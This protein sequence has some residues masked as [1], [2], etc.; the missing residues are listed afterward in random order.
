MKDW[1]SGNDW[2]VSSEGDTDWKVTSYDNNLYLQ[3]SAN[4][5]KGECIAWLITPEITLKENDYL[6]FDLKVGYWNA[7]CL[8]VWIS[9]NFDGNDVDAATW[10][11]IT[12]NFTIPQVPTGG[13]GEFANAGKCELEA[14][15]GN[16]VR[17][18]FKY[19][20]DGTK[21]ETTTYQI[22]NIMI[23]TA[24]P[25]NGGF[26]AE[27]AYA[28]KVYKKGKWAEPDKNVYLLSYKD[29]KDMG[30]NSLN[31]TSDKPAVNYIPTY[32]SKTVAY[33]LDGDARVVIYRYDNGEKISIRSDEYIYSSETTRW[34]LNNNIVNKTEQYVLKDGKWNFDPSTVI[35]LK[36]DKSDT[37][38]TVFYTAIVDWVKANKSDYI[39]SYNNNEYYYGS[40]FYQNNFDFRLSKWKEYYP[41]KTDEEVKKLMWERLPEA[42]TRALSSIYADADIVFGIDVIYTINFAVY[43]GTNPAPMYT[44][45][46]KVTGKGKFEYIA[47]SLKKQE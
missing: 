39:T 41:E 47:D 22:D 2:F 42:F 46:Y 18:A 37:E 44:I 33:P 15:A 13:Y 20:G 6:S 25:V 40:S 16:K 21:K 38:A 32:L 35:T 12:S 43:E 3:Y 5:T 27:P 29:Y 45:K 1:K 7:D 11:N 10:T 36:A 24:T 17:I 23:G 31:F 4:K 30:V 9:T 28:L 34:A 19:V 8:T 14:Y 26:D